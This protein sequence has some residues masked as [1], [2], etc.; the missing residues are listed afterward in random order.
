MATPNPR[1]AKKPQ[2]KAALEKREALICPGEGT[3]RAGAW[4]GSRFLALGDAS[5]P[6]QIKGSWEFFYS[7]GEFTGSLLDT[8]LLVKTED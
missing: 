3:P 6:G 5:A 4:S 7:S 8:L 1:K 2:S